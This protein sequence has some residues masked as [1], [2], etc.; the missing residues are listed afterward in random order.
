MEPLVSILIPA[1]NAEEFIAD[2][3]RSA[4]AQTWQRKEIIVVDDGSTDR[5]VEVARKFASKDVAFV[6]KQNQGA[7]ATRNHAYELSQGGYI[8]WL[9]ADDLLAPDKIDRQL[10]ALRGADDKWT[11]LSSSYGHFSYRTEA[12][13]FVPT[14]LWE[15]LTPVEWMLRKMGRHLSMQTATWLTSREL[16]EAAGPW[17]TRLHVDDDGEYFCR[18]L[19]LSKGT[20]F[21]PKARVYYRN[22]TS[23]RVSHVGMSDKK[24]S[25]LL[26]SMKLHIEYLRSLEESDRVRKACLNYLQNFYVEFYPERPDLM[27]ELQALATELGGRLEEPRLRWKFAWMRP[28]V[29]FQ[30]AKQAQMALPQLK[31]SLL[32][33]WDKAVYH[34][35]GDGGRASTQR[36]TTTSWGTGPV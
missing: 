36:D 34:A 35:C 20:R 5:T 24:K 32:R 17:D 6:S 28:M 18:A 11:L 15:D 1:Y 27:G 25:A 9:D 13:R 22:T 2:A 19:L 4:I 14:S 16:A 31:G 21:V 12:A 10:T 26:L 7:A 29:G 8:Q 33:K 3:I 30:A 23:T